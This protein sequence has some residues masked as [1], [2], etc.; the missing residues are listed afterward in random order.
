MTHTRISKTVY[1]IKIILFF[2]FPDAPYGKEEEKNVCGWF[3][4]EI[5][6]KTECGWVAGDT[7]YTAFYNIRINLSHQVQHVSLKLPRCYID[8]DSHRFG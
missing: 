4:S 8:L 2:P 6:Q 5:Y 3:E 1:V 7:S